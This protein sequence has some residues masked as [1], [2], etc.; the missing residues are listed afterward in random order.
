MRFLM[1]FC[2]FRR[3]Q[4]QQKER[5]PQVDNAW[6]VHMQ[7]G[8]SGASRRGKTDEMRVLLIPGKMISPPVLAWMIQ[9]CNALALRIGGFYL[10]VF[11]AVATGAGER[12]ILGRRETA[13]Y[14]RNDMLDSER[15]GCK[16]QWAETVFAPVPGPTFDLRSQSPGDTLRQP[17]APSNPVAS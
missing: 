17:A 3:M 15:F 2:F 13:A 5:P 16:G 4:S 12:Q 11:V 10:I 1:L 7:S 6:A 14:R 8:N 9:P